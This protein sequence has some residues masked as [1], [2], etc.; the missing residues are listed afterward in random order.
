MIDTHEFVPFGLAR[1][2]AD[3]PSRI[4]AAYTVL[5]LWSVQLYYLFLAAFEARIRVDLPT[6]IRAAYTVPTRRYV[7]LPSGY[8]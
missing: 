5:L 2:R 8:D 4:R 1:I 6:R 3:H 7:S